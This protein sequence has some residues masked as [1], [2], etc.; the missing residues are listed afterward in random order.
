MTDHGAVF[1]ADGVV[2]CG[3]PCEDDSVLRY[4]SRCMVQ[5]D[6]VDGKQGQHV[7]STRR[8]GVDDA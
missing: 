4:Q 3:V 1:C 2:L 7:E 5:M 8:K 6:G